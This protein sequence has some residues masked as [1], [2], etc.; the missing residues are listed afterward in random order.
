LSKTYGKETRKAAE[1][2]EN[3]FFSKNK[4]KKVIDKKKTQ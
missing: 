2:A 3:R 1:H 4:I